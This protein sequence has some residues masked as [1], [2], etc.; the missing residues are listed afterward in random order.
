[1]ELL[2]NFGWETKGLQN[3]MGFETFEVE[4]GL[5]VPRIHCYNLREGVRN[6]QTDFQWTKVE[7][8]Q[9]SKAQNSFFHL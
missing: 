3:Q 9:E 4:E 2:R 5:I 8:E 1:M 6:K 7:G